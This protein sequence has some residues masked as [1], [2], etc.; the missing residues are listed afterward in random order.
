MKGTLLILAIMGAYFLFSLFSMLLFDHDYKDKPVAKF[1]INLFVLPL[2]IPYWCL[3]QYLH[4]YI[5][6]RYRKDKDMKAPNEVSREVMMERN[7]IRT[8]QNMINGLC[9]NSGSTIVLSS[10][11]FMAIF[12][13]YLIKS[14]F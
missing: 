3:M 1:F 11:Y 10:I 14:G 12:Y 9:D 13:I 6:L 5:R 4:L 8:K 7:P 2:Y